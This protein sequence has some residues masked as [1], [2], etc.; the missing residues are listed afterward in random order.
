MVDMDFLSAL[1]SGQ[2]GTDDPARAGIAQVPQAEA[3]L[4]PPIPGP[5]PPPIPPPSIPPP[6]VTPPSPDP[7]A[8]LRRQYDA[9]V[10]QYSQTEGKQGQ[11]YYNSEQSGRPKPESFDQY[12]ARWQSPTSQPG[13]A[14]ESQVPARVLATLGNARP[15]QAPGGGDLPVNLIGPQTGPY[16]ALQQVA[17]N[18]Q[19]GS[20]QA[21]PPPQAAAPQSN[22]TPAATSYG[23]LM[24]RI[25]RQIDARE[26]SGWSDNLLRF[27]LAAMAAGGKPGATTLGALGEGGL[28]ALSAQDANR[29]QDLK[30][31]LSG[32]QASNL[33]SETALRQ[34]QL[35]AVN[36]LPP[37]PGSAAA[38]ASGGTGATPSGTQGPLPPNMTKIASTLS[39]LGH[40]P[41]Q[42]AGALGWATAESGAQD[43]NTRSLNNTGKDGQLGGSYGWQQW[44]AERRDQ[45]KDFAKSQ[46]GRVDDPVIQAK[47]FDHEMRTPGSG[48][49][50]AAQAAYWNANSPDRAVVAM[51]HY[52][53]GEGYSPDNPQGTVGF[54]KRLAAAQQIYGSI[55]GSGASAPPPGSSTQNG[56]M[57]T[58]PQAMAYGR[59]LEAAGRKEE[60]GAWFKYADPQ[61]N[62]SI[63]GATEVAKN[64]AKYAEPQFDPRIVGATEAAKEG[65]KIQH[66]RDGYI[67]RGGQI[68]GAVPRQ[69]EVTDAAGNESK[70]WITP[71]IPGNAPVAADQPGAAATAGAAPN[72]GQIGP[73]LTTKIGPGERERLVKRGME[74]ETQRQSVISQADAAQTQ[75]AALQNMRDSAP[76]I[77]TGPFAPHAQ[78]AARWLRYVSPSFDGQVS[79]YEDFTK[80]SGIVL[81]AVTREVSS[82]EAVQGLLLFKSQLPDTDQSPKG[83]DRV[84]S[85]FMGLNDFKIVKAQAQKD[86]EDQHQGSI[87]GFE[88]TFQ[89]QV[90]PLAFMFMRLSPSDQAELAGKLS[91]T[92]EG[93]AL[94]QKLTQQIGLV[95]R[96]GYDAVIQ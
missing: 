39:Q 84:S 56:V 14:G 32:A 93:Q 63:V 13:G 4:P 8:D 49:G 57:V 53:R 25:L 9:A 73:G 19:G 24:D 91:S 71:P 87:A 94:K 68:V 45:L 18:A 67:M 37:I 20:Q 27:G 46:S 59:A 51:A 11:G 48:A 58:A 21:A 29:G 7:D 41:A 55:A 52:G 85:Q 78:E 16:A 10:A 86:W 75:Q 30:A 33:L 42:I 6:S 69:V 60:A 90:T 35:A 34:N 72:A 65:Q 62:P 38:P 64:V 31:L 96:S 54:S 89:K 5:S 26:K 79:N 17:Q 44:L 92:T 50:Q 82:R 66:T 23:P 40:N 43:T 70:I 77:V 81:R 61:F 2:T 36:N 47:F 80:N 88:T 76:N 28:S 95:K 83:F 3:P 74:E 15:V 12:R 22:G 1:F